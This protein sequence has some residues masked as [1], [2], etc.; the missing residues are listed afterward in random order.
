MHSKKEMLIVKRMVEI[1]SPVKLKDLEGKLGIF[2][3]SFVVGLQ[4]KELLDTEKMIAINLKRQE[5]IVLMDRD[6]N[7]WELFKN[8]KGHY[9]LKKLKGKAITSSNNSVKT[10]QCFSKPNGKDFSVPEAKLNDE[11]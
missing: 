5:S 8:K 11:R 7:F 9:N 2:F 3:R 4:K 10:R 6:D 1:K